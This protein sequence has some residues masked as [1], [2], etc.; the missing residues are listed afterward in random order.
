MSPFEIVPA[1][2]VNQKQD[3]SSPQQKR[4]KKTDADSENGTRRFDFFVTSDSKILSAFFKDNL[5]KG[6]FM[7]DQD[8]VLTKKKE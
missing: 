4:D 1:A 8:S 5:D 6:L 7:A 3:E 2:A